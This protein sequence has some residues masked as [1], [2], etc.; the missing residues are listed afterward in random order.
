MQVPYYLDYT[1]EN[2]HYYCSLWANLWLEL[3]LISMVP[4][5]FPEETYIYIDHLSLKLDF[6]HKKNNDKKTKQKNKETKKQEQKEK[7]D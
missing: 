7:N 4:A 6:H 3:Q 5:L 1:C 2:T